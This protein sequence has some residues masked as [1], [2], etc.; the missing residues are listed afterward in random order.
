MSSA[1]V[2]PRH[3]V[4][5]ARVSDATHRAAT[6]ARGVRHPAMSRS[7]SPSGYRR[8]AHPRV[9]SRAHRRVPRAVG[10]ARGDGG[11][12]K[13]A[14]AV[15]KTSACP[16]CR[17]AEAALREAGIAFVEIDASDAEGV[18]RDAASAV[19]GMRT[20]PQV[21]VGG[22]CVGGADDTI[23]AIESGELA[24]RVARAS[25]D[26]LDATP[27]SLA[28]AAAAAAA[29]AGARSV[30]AATSS[31]SSSSGFGAETLDLSYAVLDDA[32]ERMSRDLT[33]RDLWTF[34]GW[35]RPLHLERRVVFGKDIAA[36][37]ARDEK[38]TR[39]FSSLFPD[40][41][42]RVS[43]DAKIAS[44]ASRM[45]ELGLVVSADGSR[46]LDE[47]VVRDEDGAG[48][49]PFRL[50]D[51]AAA[52]SAFP[53]AK[54]PAALNARRRFRG[55]ARDA[56]EVAADLR[57][58]ILKLHDAFLSENGSFVDYAAMRDSDAFREYL[59]AAE[60]LQTVSLQAL[61]KDEKTAFFVNLY[62]A[63][64]VHVTVVAG[65]PHNGI[66]GFFDRLSY[67]DRHAYEVEGVMY[68]CDDIE[69]GCLRGNQPSAASIGA[70]VG[71][72]KLSRGPFANPNDPRRRNAIVPFD[73]RVHFALNCGAKS[74][75]PIRLYDGDNLETQLAAA[76]AAFVESETSVGEFGLDGVVVNASKIVG[77]WYK[78]DF[79]LDDA[80][81]VAALAAYAGEETPLG[82]E[83]K[84]AAQTPGVVIATR[85]YDWD[86]NGTA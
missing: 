78:W 43:D 53:K 8:H 52:P 9:R 83:L 36:W 4:P 23:A 31:A 47:R 42:S 28:A 29:A 74:C 80:A 70:I 60:S 3:V 21:F 67:F 25:A 85:E 59:R 75:P 15:V 2:V 26:A 33:P 17:R 71:F 54:P 77:D 49:I 63:L 86:L 14:V 39:A 11:E 65:P 64:V 41:D 44:I 10:D 19:S 37:I 34:G 66:T 20:V 50:A 6:T 5:R 18:V 13:P 30:R 61:T 51:H 56:R 7:T 48:S 38:T 55:P 16:H 79:G 27:P 76:A 62:N 72:P 32:A 68:T 58:R 35:R 45:C 1:A 82:L 12:A 22:A 46:A 84:R 81:R 69:H 57:L 73:P 24:E 40:A